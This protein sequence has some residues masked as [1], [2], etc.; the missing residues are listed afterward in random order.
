MWPCY[1]VHVHITVCMALLVCVVYQPVHSC[2][3]TSL[4]QLDFFLEIFLWRLF[5]DKIIFFAICYVVPPTH[6]CGMRHPR[7][8]AQTNGIQQ[9]VHSAPSVV[10]AR[11]LRRCG[12]SQLHSKQSSTEPSQRIS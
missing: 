3:E 10:P 11:K 12:K 4:H 1:G 8:C 7:T 5:S 9:P 2:I 6:L